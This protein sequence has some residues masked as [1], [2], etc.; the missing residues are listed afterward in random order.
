MKKMKCLDCN[1]MFEAETPDEMMNTMMPHYMKKHT[2]M[3]KGQNQE[4]KKEWMQR[5]HKDWKAAKEI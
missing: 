5:F 4:T 2:D 3:M 1:E